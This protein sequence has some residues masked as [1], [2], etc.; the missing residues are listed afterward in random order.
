MILHKYL[1]SATNRVEIDSAIRQ[2]LQDDKRLAAVNEVVPDF[3]KYQVAGGI[4]SLED[5]FNEHHAAQRFIVS[6][7]DIAEFK[8]QHW[9][10]LRKICYPPLADL[11]DALAKSD[12]TQL[13][14]YQK[15]CLE[16]K[17][18]FPKP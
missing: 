17:Q 5:Y 11:A 12:A 1:S 9:E 8:K 13:E 3:I 16:V 10:E 15:A 2:A 18:W 4:K 6:D 7:S 14:Q